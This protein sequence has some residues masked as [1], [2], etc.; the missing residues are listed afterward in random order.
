MSQPLNVES[1][2]RCYPIVLNYVLNNCQLC[3]AKA[4]IFFVDRGT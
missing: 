1:R 3:R 4:V 2:T